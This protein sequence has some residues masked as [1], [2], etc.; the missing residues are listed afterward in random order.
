MA[1]QVVNVLVYQV[2]RT[3]LRTP[4]TFGVSA[5][6]IRTSIQPSTPLRP[7]RD[8]GLDPSLDYRVYACIPQLNPSGAGV[9]YL[10]TN[11][12]VASIV[13]DINT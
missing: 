9:T 10:F 11:Q 2:G 1:K 3:V 8:L 7:A 4:Q 13:S 5:S 12:T 6:G